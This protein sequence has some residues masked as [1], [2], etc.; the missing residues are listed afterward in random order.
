MLADL[1]I[2]S[3]FNSIISSYEELTNVSKNCITMSVNSIDGSLYWSNE[4]KHIYS[5]DER[6]LCLSHEKKNNSK[7]KF[8]YH[9]CYFHFC[10]IVLNKHQMKD[11]S[12]YCTST[13]L[14]TVFVYLLSI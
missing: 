9:K 3:S 10:N 14:I 5:I 11:I 7:S 8:Y 1:Y 13:I 4:D 6:S 12:N 2:P